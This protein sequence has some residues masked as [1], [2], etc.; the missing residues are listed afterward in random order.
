[1]EISLKER[2][3]LLEKTC[4]QEAMMEFVIEFINFDDFNKLKKKK[5][6]VKSYNVI[7]LLVLDNIENIIKQDM[8]GLRLFL[9]RLDSDCRKLKLILT[10]YRPLD[11]SI[12]QYFIYNVLVK[13]LSNLNS[14]EHFL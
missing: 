9:Q 14:V 8:D 13:N 1:M 2:A 5:Q 6:R 11:M 4:S 7:F 3:D 12:N 10:S